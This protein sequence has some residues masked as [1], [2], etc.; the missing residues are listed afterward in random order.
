MKQKGERYPF[1]F[2]EEVLGHTG[3]TLEVAAI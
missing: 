3:V 2:T 1:K